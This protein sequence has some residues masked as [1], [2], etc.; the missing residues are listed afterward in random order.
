M[1][2][3]AEKL[4]CANRRNRAWLESLRPKPDEIDAEIGRII[5]EARAKAAVA[6][7]KAEIVDDLRAKL[8][9]HRG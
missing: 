5:A 9:A 4:F 1:M 8:E 7:A 6:I 3:L 2:W